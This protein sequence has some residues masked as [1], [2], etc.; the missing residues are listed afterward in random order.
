LR[1]E[2][3][4]GEG[5]LDAAFKAIDKATGIPVCLKAYHLSAVT[6]GKD[7]VGEVTAKVEYNNKVFIGRGISTDILEAS[8]RAYLSAINKVVYEMGDEALAAILTEA[9]AVT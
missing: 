3:A 6:G 8:A 5:P 1:E 4:C 9:E 7:A 2:A